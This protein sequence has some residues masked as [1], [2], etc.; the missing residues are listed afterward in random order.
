MQKPGISC[1]IELF[2]DYRASP[3]VHF[4]PIMRRIPLYFICAGL[5][6]ARYFALVQASGSFAAAS[7]S[8]PQVLRLVAA[9]NALFAVAF[10]FLGFDGNRYESYHPLLIVGK[11]VA[12]FSGIIALPRLFGL[13]GNPEPAIAATFAILGVTLWDAASVVILAFKRRSTPDGTARPDG[14]PAPGEPE[15]VE[16]D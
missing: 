11:L 10:F 12:L 3:R 6:L 16:L 15:L 14:Q 8:T 1:Q 2:L 4:H 5:E 13:G 9:P 7:L